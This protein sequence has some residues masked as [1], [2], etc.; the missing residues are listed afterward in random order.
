[1]RSI[2]NCCEQIAQRVERNK[3]LL[4]AIACIFS[5]VLF[6]HYYIFATCRLEYPLSAFYFF[7]NLFGC[8]F[9]VSVVYALCYLLSGMR[10]RASLVTT[11]IL[12]LV[13]SFCN[14]MY[15]RFFGQYL[16]WSAICQAG[17]LGDGLVTQS[18]LTGFRWAD[19]WFVANVPLFYACA[20]RITK[21]KMSRSFTIGYVTLSLSVLVL[22]L[23]VQFVDCWR[24]SHAISLS[25]YR[26]TVDNAHLNL[27]RL[28]TEPKVTQFV[29]GSIRGIMF[30]VVHD[31]FVDTH[32]TDNQRDEIRAYYTDYSERDVYAG[33]A[34]EY[35]NVIFIVVESLL[36]EVSDLKVDG[37]EITPC[38]NNLKRL[39]GTV[40]NGK[41][42]PNITVGQSS[43]G[44]FIYMTGLLPLRDEVTV[45]KA[46][47]CVF[48]ALPKQISQLGSVN[49]SRMVIPT[50]ATMWVQDRM[51][52]A[53]G[54]DKLVSRPDVDPSGEKEDLNDADVFRAAS[55][56]D[57]TDSLLFS[58]ILTVS[59]HIP[60]DTPV[61]PS[62]TL[63][64]AS[65]PSR[66][67][68]YLIACH[69]MDAQLQTYLNNLKQSGV[70]D[71]CLIVIV[72]DHHPQLDLI[73]ME[74]KLDDYIP[75]YIVNSGLS[76]EE[77]W[78]GECNQLDVYTTLLDLLEINNDWRGLGY[79]LLTNSY[80]NSVSEK[81]W[82]LS[83]WIIKGDYFR[84]PQ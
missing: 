74:G 59:M 18:V 57:K 43:D 35:K 26:H 69:Y 83:D 37:K 40:Y 14:V 51:C 41:L 52:E 56:F 64:D 81:A 6:M 62:F 71:E 3:W 17:N 53:Y 70:Y 31:M 45:S 38:L 21:R 2:L 78:K 24:K 4:L 22:G 33:E 36:A 15:S 58:T 1:M 79:S 28:S 49:H 80:H 42:H 9:D 63:S 76:N 29:R 19:L 75:L 16:S 84:N 61:D 48:P 67:K 65:L 8:A 10:L 60:Y 13:W 44:Q 50:D 30:K 32:L 23:S 77:Y 82:E 55:Q 5:N 12:L 46:S 66:Y 11:Y 72:A 20:R 27:S 47:S 25:F 73:D 7:Y 39:P 54:F 68:N 34:P